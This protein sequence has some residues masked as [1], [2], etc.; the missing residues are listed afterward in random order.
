MTTI[1]KLY[2]ILKKTG[3]DDPDIQEFIGIIEDSVLKSLATK[4]DLKDIEIGLKKDLKDTE[5]RL[6]GEI[7]NTEIRLK[8]DIANA[9]INLKQDIANVEINLKNTEIRLI[10]WVIGLLIAQTS[11]IIAIIKLF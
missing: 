8:E 10:K 3:L 9:E 1:S 4:E 11:I 6:R 7:K 5:I 2:P